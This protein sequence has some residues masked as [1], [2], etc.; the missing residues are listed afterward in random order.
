MIHQL[1]PTEYLFWLVLLFFYI[2][3]NIKLI[4]RNKLVLRQNIGSGYIPIITFSRYDLAGK[5]IVIPNLFFPFT[6]VL[7]LTCDPVSILARSSQ[8]RAVR[9]LHLLNMRL[10]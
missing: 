6:M 9:I 3:D 5:E 8:T 4:P 7:L 1:L 10:F 2:I